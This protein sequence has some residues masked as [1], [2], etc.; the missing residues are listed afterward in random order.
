MDPLISQN[1]PHL[2]NYPLQ[3]KSNIYRFVLLEVNLC[4]AWLC[5][6]LKYKEILIFFKNRNYKNR[7]VQQKL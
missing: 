5:I 4:L 1:E 3:V 6:G 7:V 2:S